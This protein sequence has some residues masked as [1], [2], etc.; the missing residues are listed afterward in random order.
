MVNEY[1]ENLC[2][3]MYNTLI[4][5]FKIAE[6]EYL[7]KME[8]FPVAKKKLLFKIMPYICYPQFGFVLRRAPSSSRRQH[9][10]RY[11]TSE[12]DN[13]GHDHFFYAIE[14]TVCT[15][16]ESLLMLYPY[17]NIRPIGESLI[18]LKTLFEGVRLW[19]YNGTFGPNQKKN[20]YKILDHYWWYKPHVANGKAIEISNRLK[21]LF[22]KK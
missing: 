3:C 1:C 7:L 11:R 9:I 10:K 8:N 13:V 22:C 21:E 5:V 14:T 4:K 2:V 17:R 6:Y 15:V 16:T 12:W 20:F 19:F 18:A